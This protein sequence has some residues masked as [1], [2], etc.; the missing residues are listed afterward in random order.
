LTYDPLGRLW[1]VSGPAGTTLFLYDGDELVA[2]YDGS[3]TLLRR[4]VHGAGADDPILWYE[5][6]GVTGRRSLFAAHQGSIIAVADAVGTRLAINAYDPY[7]I[8]GSGNVG[9]F[10]Y[11]GQ[12]WLAELGMYHYKARIYSPTLG[13]FLQTDPIGY[14]GGIN[15][16]RYAENDPV[17]IFDPQGTNPIVL[18][19]VGC[20]RIS[21]CRQG[22]IAVGREVARRV[23]PRL[24]PVTGPRPAPPPVRSEGNDDSEQ[25]EGEK[26][27]DRRE[28]QQREAKERKHGDPGYE[29]PASEDYTKWRARE[30]EREGGK[31]RRREGHDEKQPGEG[32]RTKRQI[33]EDYEPK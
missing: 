1:Q 7:G 6:A 11:T 33:D 23:V 3:G 2:E 4:F 27:K 25:V 8:P 30:A 28:R 5:G 26:A 15:L 10:Q 17:N 29:E 19:I 18:V 21:L 13:R 31:E 16:Y 24:V 14:E 9:R 22:A 32:D 20:A 12:A